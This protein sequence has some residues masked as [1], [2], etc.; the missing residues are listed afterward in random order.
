[1]WIHAASVGESMAMVPL[2]KEIKKNY[3]SLSILMTTGTVTSAKVVHDR[4][5][6]LV[7]HQYAPLDFLLTIKRFLN[8]FMLPTLMNIARQSQPVTLAC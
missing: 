7:I 4:L 8:H 6:G 5:S 2:V 1:M 3:P